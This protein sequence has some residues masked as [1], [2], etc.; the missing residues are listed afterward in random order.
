MDDPMASPF[1]KWDTAL[2]AYFEH[3]KTQDL[4]EDT[5]REDRRLL[6]EMR[7]AFASTP[8]PHDLTRS[9]ISAYFLHLKVD[10]GQST[11]SRIQ[12]AT[13]LR[14]FLRFLEEPSSQW[15][16]RLPTAP[17]SEAGRYLDAVER[18]RMWSSCPTLEHQVMLALGLGNGFRRSDM[19]RCR[20][21]DLRPTAE[22]PERVRYHGK[23]EKHYQVEVELHPELRRL[24]PEYL[25]YRE[26]LMA[27]AVQAK[28]LPYRDPGTLLVAYS[29][30]KGISSMSD[31]TIDGRF[32]EIYSNAGVDPGGQPSHSLRKTWAE[33]RL[34]A[35]VDDYSSRGE[36]PPMA[37]EMALRQVCR[38][39]RWKDVE[40]LRQS[41]FRRVMK[42]SAESWARTAL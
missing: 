36:S 19:R 27:R 10:L 5:R 29:Y 14:C 32:A 23:G 37:L 9:E 39:G 28:G 21:E 20:L 7:D 1:P 12:Y 2:E 26:A 35:L 42:P 31:T 3:R 38:E 8:R 16:P 34:V 6:Q 4:A 25:V 15:I 11:A 22:R 33:N 24:I 40:T 18:G 13:R 41:Y 30:Q 17:P